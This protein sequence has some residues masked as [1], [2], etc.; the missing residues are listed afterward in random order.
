MK[1]MVDGQELFELNDTQ[2]KVIQNDIHLDDFDADMKRRLT[3]ILM[4]K[5]E[6]CFERLK[7]EWEPRLAQ[8]ERGISSVPLDKDAFAQLVF[9]QPD[10]QDRKGREA[11]QANVPLTGK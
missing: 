8:K 1:I 6:R 7:K 11:A 9:S 5:Y 10:Y 2:K 3:Y 4:H